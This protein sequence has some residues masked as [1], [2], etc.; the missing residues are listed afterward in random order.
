MRSSRTATAAPFLAPPWRRERRHP[1][2]RIHSH[3]PGGL[4]SSPRQQSCRGFL[5]R[6]GRS[7]A[8]GPGRT[9]RSRCRAGVGVRAM[10]LDSA[11]E[12][13]RGT[14]DHWQQNPMSSSV[15]MLQA[16]SAFMTAC[17]HPR[18]AP[19]QHGTTHLIAV[20]PERSFKWNGQKM[21]SRSLSHL[22]GEG[23]GV[24][25]MSRSLSH[26][27]GEGEGVETVGRRK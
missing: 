12:R 8:G 21:M 6:R 7:G 13:S 18:C 14:A 3:G 19:E 1:R 24:E 2:C 16:Y 25:M 23:E 11:R 4:P 9:A 10:G 20:G 22:L 26:L 5:L 17:H 15:H 27:L